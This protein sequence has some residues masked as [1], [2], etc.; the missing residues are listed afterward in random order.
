MAD[1]DVGLKWV[2]LHIH[3]AHVHHSQHIKIHFFLLRLLSFLGEFQL[4]LSNSHNMRDWVFLIFYAPNFEEVEGAYIFMPPTSKKLK[5]H[6]GLVLSVCPVHEQR[7]A[8]CQE[9]LELGS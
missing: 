6:I 7:L 8:L 4:I 9:P 3:N 5:G 2:H 1:C